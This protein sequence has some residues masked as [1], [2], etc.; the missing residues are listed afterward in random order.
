[1]IFPQ[2]KLLAVP[3]QTQ[4]SEFPSETSFIFQYAKVSDQFVSSVN[5]RGF[6]CQK[7]KC[8]TKWKVSG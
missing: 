5:L 2:C 7:M 6:W 8:G 4:L 3:S 1:M